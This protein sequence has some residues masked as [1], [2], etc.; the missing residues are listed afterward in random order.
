MMLRSRLR[1]LGTR[2][3][4]LIEV[5]VIIAILGI[6]MGIFGLNLLRSLRQS[7]LREAASQL[8]GD[9]RRSRADRSSPTTRALTR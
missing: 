4:T 8:A 9:L 1:R 5:L 6:I 2:G 3:F 7:Q